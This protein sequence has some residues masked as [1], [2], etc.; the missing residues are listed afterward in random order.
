MDPSCSYS[1]SKAENLVT[2]THVTYMP[3]FRYAPS[4]I[5]L[6]FTKEKFFFCKLFL[7]VEK[8]ET[9]TAKRV[10]SLSHKTNNHILTIP[11]SRWPIY[12]NLFLY[13]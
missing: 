6:A 5:S 7:R 4:H 1:E 13:V 11:L 8:K 9:G 3:W 2:G 12:L 10:Q